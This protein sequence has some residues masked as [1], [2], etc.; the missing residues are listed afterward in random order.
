MRSTAF[1][2]IQQYNPFQ[3]V[4][5]APLA[6]FRI[7]FGAVMAGGVVR[8]MILGWIEEQ[9]IKP[10]VHFAY[11]GFEWVPRVHDWLQAV[12]GG[13]SIYVVFG[14]MLLSALGVMLGA[15]YRFSAVAY[16]LT[17][18]FVELI[19]KTY[20]LNHYYFVSV[21]ALLLCFVPANCLCS[22]DCGRKT[23]QEQAMAPRWMIDVL[24]LQLAFVYVYAGLAKLHPEWILNAMPLRIWL[25]AN[26]T[27]P[28]IGYFFREEWVAYLFSWA[29]MIYDTTIV[30]FLL[31]PNTR[32]IAFLAVIVFHTLTGILFQIGVFPVVMIALTPIYFSEQFHKRCIHALSKALPLLNQP[33]TTSLENVTVQFPR[34]TLVIWL[35]TLHCLVQILVPW[36]CLLYE[37]NMF[38]TEEGYRFGWRVMLMEKAG[39]ATLYVRDTA[40]GREGAVN[41]R[42]FLNI[43]QEKQMAMQPDMI[44]QFAHILRD[45]YAAK[46]VIEP[47]VRAE[48]YVTLNARP[49]RLYL[50]SSVN[51]AREHETFAQK[52]WV[53][54]LETSTNADSTARWGK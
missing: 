35:L 29:G 18:T 11:W 2:F 46:G 7:L 34:K 12:S 20:Y 49:S 5:A 9:Y 8:F 10:K 51:L 4:S 37:G 28:I 25:P 27:V 42:E 30:G 15:W 53:L 39:T 13:V 6:M 43:H 17:F 31:Y 44:L 3:A 24:K 1:R 40:S 33:A 23:V 22:V 47:A 32:I 19:D 48:V 41:N 21:V 52:T 14:V 36:R 45:H 38:W 50:D 16:F 26:D 54:P